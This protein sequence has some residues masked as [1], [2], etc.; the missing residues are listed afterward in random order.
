MLRN[1]SQMNVENPEKPT[2][3]T[4]HL[5]LRTHSNTQRE[6]ASERERERE[7]YW[8]TEAGKTVKEKALYMVNNNSNNKTVL[9]RFFP[10]LF[11]NVEGE[12]NCSEKLATHD[13]CSCNNNNKTPKP[14]SA[15]R[16]KREKSDR[17]VTA[18]VWKR[19][20]NLH[21][22]NMQR[23]ERTEKIISNAICL[24][25]NRFNSYGSEAYLYA[26]K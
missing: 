13:E 21:R 2:E 9:Y 8:K 16:C 15:A 14:T 7:T 1:K 22:I 25:I 4:T 12:K 3:L 26:F 11:T 5:Y 17:M 19:V 20:Y 23:E 10:S 18:I 24:L 6:R